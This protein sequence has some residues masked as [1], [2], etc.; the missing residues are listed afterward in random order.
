MSVASVVI[1]T[2]HRGA[3]TPILECEFDLAYSPLLQWQH[4]KGLILFCQ[5]DLTGRIDLEPAAGVLAQNLIGYLD[6][7][8]ARAQ[9]KRVVCMGHGDEAASLVRGLGFECA[10]AADPDE[11][12][13]LSP[14]S[15]LL[16]VGSGA[17][18]K[19]VPAG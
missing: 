5:L 4:G 15:H 7:Q 13:R 16:V 1:E 17:L 18:P 9:A 2:P 12:S 6:A 3:F 8:Q 14:A 19:T 11:L 10:E